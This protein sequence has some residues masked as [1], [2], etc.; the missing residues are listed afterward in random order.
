[1]I[2]SEEHLDAAVIGAVDVAQGR[3]TLRGVMGEV[4]ADS[5]QEVRHTW[6]KL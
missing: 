6:A 1:M 3:E 2:K 4:G 5:E